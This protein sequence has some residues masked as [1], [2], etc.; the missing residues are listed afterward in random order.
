MNEQLFPGPTSA[1]PALR[2]AFV[3]TNRSN[4]VDFLSAGLLRPRAA[5]TKYYPDTL[6]LADRSVPVILGPPSEELVELATKRPTQF[7]VLVEVD[8][9]AVRPT[10]DDRVGYLTVETLD[11]VVRVLVESDDDRDELTARR[12]D[13][14]DWSRIDILVSPDL[15][16]GGTVT[17]PEVRAAITSQSEA[18]VERDYELEDRLG[19]ARLLL[20]QAAPRDPVRLEHVARLVFEP[21]LPR[22]RKKT[23]AIADWLRLDETLADYKPVKSAGYDERLFRAA[24]ATCLTLRRE[25]SWDGVRLVDEIDRL[26]VADTALRAGDRKR[27]A[28]AAERIRSIVDARRTFQGFRSAEYTTETAVLLAALRGGI[29]D[30]LAWGEEAIGGDRWSPAVAA[31]L[32]GLVHGRTAAGS[33]LR[34]RPLDEILATIERDRLLGNPA[35]R[36]VEVAAEGD[37]LSVEVDGSRMLSV[38]Q[39]TASTIEMVRRLDFDDQ[40]T[41][42]RLLEIASAQGWDDAIKT[43]LRFNGSFEHHVATQG[44]EITVRGDVQAVRELDRQAFEQRA[45]V[46]DSDSLWKSLASIVEPDTTDEETG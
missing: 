45:E 40:S 36:S 35:D 3:V 42:G 41:I 29:D 28:A 12:F 25:D 27:W 8:P 24:A 46:D 26:L 4:I 23:S 38:E 37:G 34:D 39:A 44:S 15:F 5:M 22:G 30:V 18:C 2:Q 16:R 33:S 1:P 31:L 10:D 6:E 43:T 32:I 14:V 11:R 17:G 21:A 20:L 13:N 7:P 19:G 9:D